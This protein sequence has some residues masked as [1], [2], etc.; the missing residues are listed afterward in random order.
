MGFIPKQY[1]KVFKAFFCSDTRAHHKN[2]RY[3]R[4][5]CSPNVMD[6]FEN[7]LSILRNYNFNSLFQ[8]TFQGIILLNQVEHKVYEKK[9][10]AL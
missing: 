1:L 4:W 9:S 2:S 10:H 7:F 6:P 8:K 3:G 5:I